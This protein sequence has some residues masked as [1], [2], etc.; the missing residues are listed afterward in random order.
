M[1]CSRPP[2]GPGQACLWNGLRA[3]S[4]VLFIDSQRPWIPRKDRSHLDQL[5]FS[6]GFRKGAVGSAS[7]DLHSDWDRALFGVMPGT[8]PVILFRSRKESLP[9]T[10]GLFCLAYQPGSVFMLPLGQA[11]SFL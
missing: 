5:R 11:D 9:A 8:D 2:G 3:L 4:G 10:W 6:L 7:A 1:G